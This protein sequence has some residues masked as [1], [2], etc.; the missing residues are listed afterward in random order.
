MAAKGQGWAQA[1][2]PAP[3]IAKRKGG[4]QARV[5]FLFDSLATPFSYLT[6]AEILNLKFLL[7]FQNFISRE[8]IPKKGT[9][10]RRA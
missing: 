3:R 8:Q 9:A 1:R 6:K 10:Q 5:R 2:L 4:A 7:Q